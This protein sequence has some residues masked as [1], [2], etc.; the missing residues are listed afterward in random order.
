MKKETTT[1][2]FAVA[3]VAVIL[4]V[5]KK[6]SAGTPNQKRL[7]LKANFLDKIFEFS[8]P[9]LGKHVVRDPLRSDLG[10]YNLLT[11]NSKYDLGWQKALDNLVVV[12]LLHKQGTTFSEVYTLN[13]DTNEAKYFSELS[14]VT[15]TGNTSA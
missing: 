11:A 3:L 7:L 15:I 14:P 1:I 4:L 6:A 2:I 5:T 13:F 8:H 9:E 10:K 12:T